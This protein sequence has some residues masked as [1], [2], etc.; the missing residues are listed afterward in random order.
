MSDVTRCKE[1]LLSWHAS[2]FRWVDAP[3]RRNAAHFFGKFRIGHDAPGNGALWQV[4][5]GRLRDPPLRKNHAP[6]RK[7]CQR[8]QKNSAQKRLGMQPP[9]NRWPVT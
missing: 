5:A 8:T 1:I 6:D 2:P 9:E 4:A 7:S 3:A